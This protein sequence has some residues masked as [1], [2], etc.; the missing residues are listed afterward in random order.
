VGMPRRRRRSSSGL[1]RAICERLG[2]GVPVKTLV[3]LLGV[4][5]SILAS[6]SSRFS[7][8]AS[9]HANCSLGSGSWAFFQLLT[10]KIYCGMSN[11][12]LFHPTSIKIVLVKTIENQHEHK[13]GQVFTIVEIHRFLDPRP[14]GSLYLHPHVIPTILR[15]LP[16]PDSLH[17]QFFRKVGQKKTKPNRLIV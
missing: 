5:F 15:F 12:P 8:L 13:I 7:N 10:T 14:F 4:F 1:W 2:F 3:S 17:S 6:P 16:Q 11:A 9:K